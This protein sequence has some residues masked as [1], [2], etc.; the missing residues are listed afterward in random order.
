MLGMTIACTALTWIAYFVEPSGS[1]AWISIFERAMVT[2]VVWLTFY[3]VSRRNAAIAMLDRQTR[4]LE[5]TKRELERS[6]SE[7]ERFASVVAHD[8][9]N[10]LNSIGLLSQLLGDRQLTRSPAESAE[11]A[12]KIQ[13]QIASLSNLIESLLSYGRVGGG[14]LRV[15]QCDCDAV[16]DSVL[17]K[18]NS[19]I[20]VSGAE[21]TN[22]PLPTI[23]A[24]AA[25]IGELFQNLI[26]NGIKY[27]SQESPRIHISVERNSD[28]W[29]FSIRDNGIG[30][31]AP[32]FERIF[33]PF[34]QVGRVDSRHGI[35]L[36]LATCKRIVE[37]HGGDL[38]VEST[39]DFGTTFTFTI[40]VRTNVDAPTAAA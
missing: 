20:E 6:N 18:L 16:L 28:R 39:V 34:Q 22:D 19:L 32:D 25:L 24:D 2:G 10:P 4:T 11:W 37:R 27:R 12:A 40:P 21:V 17:Q 13:K 9:R 36:G 15:A 8:I 7:L 14:K 29:R 23:A 3:L 38:E 35:G 5:E 31:S 33:Q 26:E 1:A 30:I